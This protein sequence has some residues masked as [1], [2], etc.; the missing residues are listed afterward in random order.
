MQWIA[1]GLALC[2]SC[3]KRTPID[4]SA[5]LGLRYPPRAAAAPAPDASEWLKQEWKEELAHCSM[6]SEARTK[7][8]DKMLNEKL[9]PVE[10]GVF[11]EVNGQGAYSAVLAAVDDSD[12]KVYDFV[13]SE[14]L[15]VT[16]PS[17]FP[18]V[19]K[20][21]LSSALDRIEETPR[22]RLRCDVFVTTVAD[23]HVRPATGLDASQFRLSASENTNSGELVRSLLG[24]DDLV[25]SYNTHLEMTR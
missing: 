16:H 2:L 18:L 15:I 4:S 6:G 8:L 1:C 11:M 9:W 3:H 20:Q 13:R 14:W 10:G 7:L 23:G 21:T 19:R 24:V 5:Q 12:I 25:A 22:Q 17:S